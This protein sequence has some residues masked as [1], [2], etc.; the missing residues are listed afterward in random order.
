MAANISKAKFLQ[1]FIGVRFCTG[2][3][4]RLQS[5]R[6]SRC[7]CGVGTKDKILARERTRVNL[8]FVPRGFS[9]SIAR[10]SQIR[11]QNNFQVSKDALVSFAE[12][13]NWS[14]SSDELLINA[15]THKS[16]V[17]SDNDVLGTS[18]NHNGRLIHLGYE[19]ASS[20]ITEILYFKHPTLT[21]EQLWDL[22]NGLLRQD[23]LEKCARELGLHDLIFSKD[24]VSGQIIAE[25]LLAIIGSIYM[26][27][28][29]GLT[30]EFMENYVVPELTEETIKEICQFEHPKFMLQQLNARMNLTA[31]ILQKDSKQ[32]VYGD[33]TEKYEVGIFQQDEMICKGE[34][35]SQF[36]AEK[37]AC[38]N[39][40]KEIY[41]DKLKKAKFPLDYDEFMSEDEINLGLLAEGIRA[42]EIEKG[43]S[44]FGFSLK[45]GEMRSEENRDFVKY[46]YYY[47]PF[48]SS[49]VGGGPAER[50]GLKPGDVILAVND[51]NTKG[52]GHHKMVKL[53]ESLKGKAKFTVKFSK[54]V[55]ISDEIE[56]K[57]GQFQEGKLLSQ[58]TDPKWSEWHH[59][60]SKNNRLEYDTLVS[61]RQDEGLLPKITKH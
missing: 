49:V 35:D 13:I 16:Y 5:S 59:S 8:K 51:K 60:H 43:E 6:F 42:V 14:L 58:L 21:A 48:I 30:R 3:Q 33:E 46:H 11:A 31:K 15:L 47:P 17:T 32:D 52:M 29:P 34:G 26:N 12:K 7:V 4:Q 2:W 45:G 1:S 56:R 53:L 50:C 22:Q 38:Q 20:F 41:L 54:K 19:T 57:F 23:L 36:K 55:L 9:T 44:G 40:L 61:K 27:Q 39:L 28:P 18:F 25:A 24:E 10:Y 37:N